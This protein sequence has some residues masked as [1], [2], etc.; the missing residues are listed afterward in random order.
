MNLSALIQHQTPSQQVD[1]S[2]ASMMS[3]SYHPNL[4]DPF[5][6]RDSYPIQH[7]GVQY[8]M[9]NTFSPQVQPHGMTSPGL[10]PESVP[11]STISRQ[12]LSPLEHIDLEP[13]VLENGFPN[14]NLEA[15]GDSVGSGG[16]NMDVSLDY[17]SP[18]TLPGVEELLLP[19]GPSVP[20][21]T[22]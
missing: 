14:F 15:N 7:P 4:D 13:L 21:S 18:L 19:E 12:P 9:Q 10:P 20:P 5:M 16:D 1:A 3:A 11:M 6:N 8:L 17:H 2:P 22:L